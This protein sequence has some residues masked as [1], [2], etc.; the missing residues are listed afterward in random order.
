MSVLYLDDGTLVGP[1]AT[2]AAVLADLNSEATKILGLEL[3]M[4]KCEVWWPSGDQTFAEFPRTVER[5]HGAWRVR[6]QEDT[7]SLDE[8]WEWVPK[9][10]LPDGVDILKIPVGSDE[11]VAQRLR[12]K[13][14]DMER[15]MNKLG[16]IEDAQV[17]FTM[18]RACL[19]ACRVLYLLRGAPPGP[20]VLEVLREA[21]GHMRK[22]LERLL[23]HSVPDPA[24]AQAGLRVSEGGLGLRHALDVAYPAYLGSVMSSSA[25]VAK[26]LGK[27][28]VPC[29]VCATLLLNMPHS[30]K[31]TLLLQLNHGSNCCRMAPLQRNSVS[32]AQLDPSR[33]SKRPV[34]RPRGSACVLTHRAH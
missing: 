31:G 13:V 15:I 1:R 9:P 22:T 27:E 10:R 4:K 19:G 3:N 7:R 5:A 14:A 25:L 32:F 26:L 11:Y 23:G 34:I 2:L 20:L 24:W 33:C 21:D 28:E 12:A 16:L 18:L 17:E 29:Q 6:A 8:I 30:W